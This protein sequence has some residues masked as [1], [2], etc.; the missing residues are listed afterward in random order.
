MMVDWRQKVL[1]KIQ[2]RTLYSFGA[3][4]KVSVNGGVRTCANDITV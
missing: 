1:P 2:L 4:E 3:G